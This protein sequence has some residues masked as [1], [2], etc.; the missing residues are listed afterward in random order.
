MSPMALA[1]G[2]PAPLF[3]SLVAS[4]RVPCPSWVDRTERRNSM[5]NAGHASNASS[6]SN[7]NR[8]AQRQV[9][10]RSQ[11]DRRNQRETNGSANF[12]GQSARS[13]FVAAA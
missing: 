6:T 3:A 1:P 7:A 11:C 13:S 2:F 9:N 8:A 4:R 10:Q 5:R 12:R